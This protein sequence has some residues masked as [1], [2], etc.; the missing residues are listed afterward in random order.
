MDALT[1]LIVVI[2]SQYI[3]TYIKSVHQIDLPLLQGPQRATGLSTVS[4][5]FK[6]R[7]QQQHQ[8]MLNHNWERTPL[9]HAA[10]HPTSCQGAAQAPLAISL[11]SQ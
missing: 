8:R 4:T 9:D 3:H 1:S 11:F 7:G 6:W 2:I 5:E 10:G